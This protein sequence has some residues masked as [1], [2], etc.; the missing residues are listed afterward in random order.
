ME[1]LHYNLEQRCKNMCSAGIESL[2]H[3]ALMIAHNM[4]IHKYFHTECERENKK[5]ASTTIHG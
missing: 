3:T 1:N 2:I 5:P 4:N